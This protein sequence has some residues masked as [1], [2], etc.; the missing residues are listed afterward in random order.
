MTTKGKSD[1]AGATVCAVLVIGGVAMLADL[2]GDYVKQYTD[3]APARA[4]AA[5]GAALNA[6]EQN[7]SKLYL[8]MDP[9]IAFEAF[10]N[11]QCVRYFV[12]IK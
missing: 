10:R 1:W 11:T 6:A 5:Y 7:C 12:D 4:A 9:S 3:G 8:D 2:G